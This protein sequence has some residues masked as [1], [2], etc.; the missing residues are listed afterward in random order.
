MA[1]KNTTTSKTKVAVKVT[2]PVEAPVEAPVEDTSPSVDPAPVEAP[3]LHTIGAGHP[4]APMVVPGVGEQKT[5]S[6]VHGG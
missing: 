2:K 3:K 6:S 1:K 4:A 5:S